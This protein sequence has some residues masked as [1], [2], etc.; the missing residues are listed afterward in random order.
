M[1]SKRPSRLPRPTLVSRAEPDNQDQE[2]AITDPLSDKLQHRMHKDV[3]TNADSSMT[4]SFG[5]IWMLHKRLRRL[6]G[7]S[8]GKPPRGRIACEKVDKAK[9]QSKQSKARQPD[10]VFG[11]RGQL[12]HNYENIIRRTPGAGGPPFEFRIHC[13]TISVVTVSAV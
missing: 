4:F 3:N 8:S 9:K 7:F 11:R 10:C 12:A 1:P 2:A 6:E 5:S 13:E